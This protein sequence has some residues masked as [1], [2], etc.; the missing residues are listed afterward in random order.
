MKSKNI[1]SI[2]KCLCK[3][4][5]K[6]NTLGDLESLTLPLFVAVVTAVVACMSVTFKSQEWLPSTAGGGSV[7]EMYR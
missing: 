2:Y 1:I 5:P 7:L 3:C 6:C 4:S